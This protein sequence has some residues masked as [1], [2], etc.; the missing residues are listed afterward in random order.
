[1]LPPFLEG[2]G[3][4]AGLIIAIGAQ[5][6]FVLTQGVRREHHLPVALVCAVCDA[7]LILI[8]VAGMG[9]ALAASPY[10]A[11]T[12][13]LAGAGFL[14]FYG[15]HAAKLALCGTAG[16]TCSS[17][18]AQRS[19][20][21]VLGMTLVVTLCNPHVYVDTMLLLG[22]IGGRHTGDSK[23]L[24]AAGAV[25]ASFVWFYSL[26]M[27]GRLLSP[28]LSKPMAWR[29]LYGAVALIMWTVAAGLLGWQA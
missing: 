16:L 18:V 8:G 7:C 20:Q 2:A 27:G 21:R 11:L 19:L 25:T 12:M 10:L 13:A 23:W 14:G 22:S 4:G 28:W 6:V 1:M 3:T 24:F 15:L 9:A 29:V 26:A 5:N 17:E